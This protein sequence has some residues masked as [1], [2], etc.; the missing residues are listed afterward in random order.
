[1]KPILLIL[2]LALTACNA[3]PIEQDSTTRAAEPD[4]TAADADTTHTGIP[5]RADTTWGETISIPW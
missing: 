2:S 4:S 1:M 5:L 3:D